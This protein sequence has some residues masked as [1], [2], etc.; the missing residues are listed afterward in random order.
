MIN[1]NIYS[2]I[3]I[4]I[5]MIR[6]GNFTKKC[7][8][9]G[10]YKI[11]RAVLLARNPYDAIWSEYQR[12]VTN[13]HTGHIKKAEYDEKHFM[14]D[15]VELAG[16]YVNTYAIHYKS[17]KEKF[18]KNNILYIRFENFS[19]KHPNSKRR[20]VAMTELMKLVKFLNISRD[21]D[22]NTG[23]FNTVDKKMYINDERL[24]CAFLLAESPK[25]R[26]IIYLRT[27][28]Y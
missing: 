28:R 7:T 22:N 24:Q 6:I 16:Q 3:S 10:L 19:T 9:G 13:S 4:F 17:L 14:S 5:Y 15:A 18:Y 2:V 26:S 21:P 25:V 11:E 1:S 20:Q 8:D 12:R 27:S 23:N